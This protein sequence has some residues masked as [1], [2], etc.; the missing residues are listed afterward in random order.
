MLTL[1][2]RDRR[3]AE[4]IAQCERRLARIPK[5]VSG[6]TNGEIPLHFLATVCQSFHESYNFDREAA[7][8]AIN[9]YIIELSQLR[10]S[11][12]KWLDRYRKAID[13]QETAFLATGIQIVE[14]IETLV[15]FLESLL[16]LA[17]VRPKNI[18]EYFVQ[19]KHDFQDEAVIF[20]ALK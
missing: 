17:M 4:W 16:C 20:K 19:G 2:H 1:T 5:R 6:V 3:A 11:A 7:L 13:T 14:E 15:R 12:R 8:D 10:S 18:K 9:A